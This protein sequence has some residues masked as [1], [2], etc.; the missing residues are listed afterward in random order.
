VLLV[1]LVA[2]AWLTGRIYH[3]ADVTTM[4][5]V[6][7]A[8]LL[9]G[10]V[11]SGGMPK[12]HRKRGRHPVVG[13]FLTGVAVFAFTWLAGALVRLLPV[14]DHAV[15]D[16]LR[17][18]DRGSTAAL[19]L[20]AAVAGVTEEAFYRGAMFERV[21]L[22]IPM[23]AFA[24]MLATLPAGNVALTAAAGM[25]GTVCG[26]SRRASGGWWSAA[27][28]HVTWALLCVTWLPR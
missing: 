14:F 10:T 20:A 2:S 23:T 27:V 21:P 13:P 19:V 18:A 5:Y 25:L 8:V 28:V 4:T 12:A 11:L 17:K 7:A 9:A 6:L 16:V 24:H 26:L 15:V 1:T 22:P 3:S